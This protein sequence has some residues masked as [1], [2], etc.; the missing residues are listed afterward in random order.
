MR[1]SVVGDETCSSCS[2]S[3]EVV[4]AMSSQSFLMGRFSMSAIGMGASRLGKRMRLYSSSTSSLKKTLTFKGSLNKGRL[5]QL[6]SFYYFLLIIK[7]PLT[8]DLKFCFSREDLEKFADLN[9]NYEGFYILLMGKS[10]F[11]SNRKST[12]LRFRLIFPFL[13]EKKLI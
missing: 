6:F 7:N 11:H 5:L 10:S 9:H 12:D 3:A 4:V 2:L 13:V 8:R 1:H